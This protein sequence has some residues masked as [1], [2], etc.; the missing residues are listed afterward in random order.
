MVQLFLTPRWKAI[1]LVLLT[2]INL[3]QLQSEYFADVSTFFKLISH[4]FFESNLFES[5]V[6][7]HEIFKNVKAIA[8]L[9][10]NKCRFNKSCRHR[11]F[12]K[13]DGICQ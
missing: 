8:R 7:S 6:L 9:P 10:K 12:S 13:N 3:C 4:I 11:T 2:N 1:R 5:F